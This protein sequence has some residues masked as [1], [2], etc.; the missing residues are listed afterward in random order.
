ML[1]VCGVLF[2]ASAF[3][4]VSSVAPSRVLVDGERA[5]EGVVTI[6]DGGLVRIRGERTLSRVTA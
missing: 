2:G 5:P 1:A 6:S 3:V 4:D